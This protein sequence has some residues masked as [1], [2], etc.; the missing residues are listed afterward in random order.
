MSCVAAAMI[1]GILF[2]LFQPK[3]RNYI[4]A[5]IFVVQAVQLYL[6]AEYRWNGVPWGGQWFDVSVPDKLE[7]KSNLY[8]TVG[9]Q[10]NSFLVPF[11]GTSAAFINVAGA[12]MLDPQGANGARVKESIRRFAPNV[13][14]VFVT[15][16]PSEKGRPE[17]LLSSALVWY[18]LR[19]DLNDCATITVH[20][21]PP[22]LRIRLQGTIP[23]QPQNRETSFVKACRA[24]PDTTDL[25]ALI[26][27]QRAADVVFDRLED[28]CPMLFWPRHL[29]TGHVGESWQRGYG[30]TDIVASISRGRVKFSDQM[31]SHEPIDVGSASDWARAPLRLE[32]GKRDG[33]YFAHVMAA[34][35]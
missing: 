12:Y 18:G 24:V 22:A 6:G 32:C 25:S 14:V 16:D 17:P 11:L 2:R 9:A 1:V 21:L 5:I 13:R 34:S 29:K 10:S 8:L 15:D 30:G 3:V 28:A 4:L 35:E 33:V 19:P 27:D 7:A 23:L 26:A 31:R 20:G